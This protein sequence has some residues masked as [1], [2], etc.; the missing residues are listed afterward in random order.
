MP[1]PAAPH[2]RPSLATTAPLTDAELF[3]LVLDPLGD[4][5]SA[6]GSA[7]RRPGQ[8]VADVLARIGSLR[9]MST[10]SIRELERQAGLT[11][12]DAIRIA[13]VFE[14]ARR[15]LDQRLQPGEAFLNPRQIF[16]HFHARLRD[17]KKE[18]FCVVLLDARHRIMGEERIS[19]GS[20]TSSIV[21]PREVFVPAVRESAGAVVF[22][23]NHPS[24]EPSPSEDDIAVTR[25]LE[26]AA[27]LLGIRV[28]DHV[29]IGDGE[30]A[31]FKEMG[32]M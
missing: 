29:I 2:V 27:D 17:L 32:L 22:V 7:S 26:S 31:S 30:Y 13:A 4:P 20:L 21:H 8:E 12:S 1:P 23:H 6:P 3:A 11:K 15:L 18:V 24:G 28:L 14:L 16:D 10:R 25:R 9:R 19:E 5:H